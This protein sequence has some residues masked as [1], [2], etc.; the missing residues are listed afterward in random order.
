L[1]RSPAVHGPLDHPWSSP[2]A[3]LA[4]PAQKVLFRQIRDLQQLEGRFLSH[5]TDEPHST[6]LG[7]F[8]Q[9]APAPAMLA[10]LRAQVPMT[11]VSTAWAAAWR[12]KLM[13]GFG[14]KKCR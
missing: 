1:A 7:A 2:P 6:L 11:G 3:R 8:R 4:L 9:H 5:D 12:L 13:F 10:M 14:S